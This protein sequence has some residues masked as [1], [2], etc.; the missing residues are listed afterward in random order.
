MSNTTDAFPGRTCYANSMKDCNKSL[1][2]HT[3][4]QGFIFVPKGGGESA[5]EPETAVCLPPDVRGYVT[6]GI[7][8]NT[9]SWK[10]NA[11]RRTAVTRQYAASMAERGNASV[12]AMSRSIPSVSSVLNVGF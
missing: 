4:L 5:K 11:T 2:G 9:E 10:P 7:V 3:D 8:K 12:T 6:A 1:V